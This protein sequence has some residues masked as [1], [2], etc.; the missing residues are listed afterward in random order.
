MISRQPNGQINFKSLARATQEKVDLLVPRWLP[1]GHR[2]GNEWVARNPTREDRTRG[3]FKINLRRGVWFDFAT[4][5]GGGDLISLYAYLNNIRQG[6]AA[7]R[8]AK[9]I[10]YDF[11]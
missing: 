6:Q 8:I 9:E 1:D 2:E 7:H 11:A 10:G 4:G 3:S 5:E